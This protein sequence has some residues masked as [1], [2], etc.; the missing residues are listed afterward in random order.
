MPRSPITGGAGFVGS[1]L[2]EELLRR[3]EEAFVINDLFTGVQI[4]E[5]WIVAALQIAALYGLD[6]E[7][8]PGPRHPP[9]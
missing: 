6:R 1:H 7:E 4:A 5:R 8:I 3:G 9:T 2:G